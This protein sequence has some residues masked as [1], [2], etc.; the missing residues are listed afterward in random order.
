MAR[1][2]TAPVT[3][4]WIGLNRYPAVG[5]LWA[6]H[7]GLSTT[8]RD[9]GFFGAGI[10]VGLHPRDIDHLIAMLHRLQDHGNTVLVVEHDPAVFRAADWIVDIGLGAGYGGGEVVFS[11]RLDDLLHTD[12]ATSRA[13]NDRVGTPRRGRRTFDDAFRIENATSNNLRNLSVRI[14]KGVLTCVTG[15]AGSG[16]RRGRRLSA[17]RPVAVGRDTS[18]PNG[19]RWPVSR[20]SRSGPGDRWFASGLSR[21]VTE[22]R[23]ETAGHGVDTA[24]FRSSANL[25]KL[26]ILL[27]PASGLEPLTC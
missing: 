8:G 27:E 26:L 23:A 14:P 24:Q 20:N 6:L 25:C 19:S 3:E 15:V 4:K 1:R 18:E 17:P 5:L 11:G 21:G 7:S 16:N 10:T 22:T 12:T 9:R 2:V 13:L